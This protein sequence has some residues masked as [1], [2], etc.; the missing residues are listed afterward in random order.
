MKVALCLSGKVGNT[1]GKSGYHK[2]ELRVLE[3]G[4]NH[5]KEHIINKNDIDVFVHCW[6]TELSDQIDNLYNPVSSEY[7]EQIKFEIPDYVKGES[8]RKQNHYSRWY[9]NMVVNNLRKKHEIENNFK[10]DFVMTTRFDLAWETDVIFSQCDTGK[11]YA[12][13][14]SCVLDSAGR[15]VFK[16]GR[17]PLYD[18]LEKDPRNINKFTYKLK[19]YPHVDEGFLDLWFFSNS[20]NSDKFFNLYNLLD[21]YNYPGKCPTDSSDSIS[22]HR[23]SKY[24]LENLGLLKSLE[25]K[26]HMFD[27]FPEVR[28]K[29][30]GCRK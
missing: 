14:W 13:N 19:G 12:G 3:K 23:L 27:D 20:E 16:G 29:Y 10:Y 8:Q 15:D 30:F 26:F 4:Y 6:D 1:K 24:H 18:F 17:G 7:Q 22:N 9:S 11:F 25:F 2:S 28:R 21:E 5:Y